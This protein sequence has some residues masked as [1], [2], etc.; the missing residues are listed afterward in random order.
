MKQSPWEA[1]GFSASQE[2]PR[3]L[4][5]P[6]VRY[7]IHKSPPQVTRGWKKNGFC[8]CFVRG[9]K[10]ACRLD[11]RAQIP[12]I[13]VRS[14]EVLATTTDELSRK[15][16]LIHDPGLRDLTIF[17]YYWKIWEDRIWIVSYQGTGTKYTQNTGGE[18]V[19]KSYLEDLAFD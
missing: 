17:T 14:G 18:M 10:H 1:N 4:W 8:C 11:C 12:S 9:M 13:L 6:K 7:R 5:N 15:V 16:W 19:H 3:I 2:I